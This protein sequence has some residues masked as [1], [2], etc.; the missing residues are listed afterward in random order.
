MFARKAKC[1][2]RE[3]FLSFYGGQKLSYDK[4]NTAIKKAAAMMDS[5]RNV[6]E[7]IP[8]EWQAQQ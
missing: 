3:Q 2:G 4:Y 6:S 1:A 8:P 7:H 5:I